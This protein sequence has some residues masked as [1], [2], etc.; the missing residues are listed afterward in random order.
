MDRDAPKDFRKIARRVGY[1][2]GLAGLYHLDPWLD[3]GSSPDRFT[4]RGARIIEDT[5]YESYL[6][7]ATDRLALRCLKK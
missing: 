5:Y 3:V 2:V 7:G 4:A 6:E 1:K